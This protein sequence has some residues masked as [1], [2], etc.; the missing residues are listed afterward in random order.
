MD[1]A[2]GERVEAELNVLITRRHEKRRETEGE[3]QAE[4]AWLESERR[5]AERRREENRAAW[6]CYHR[7]QA[8]S[9]R[10]TLT[11]L[12]IH[13]QAEAERYTADTNGHHEE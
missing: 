13:H 4:E 2:H 9:H 3:R 6:A 1:I 5:H 12:I 11:D 7:Q 10:A 8:E